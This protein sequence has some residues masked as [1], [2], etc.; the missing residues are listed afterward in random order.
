MYTQDET[1]TECPSCDEIR[2]PNVDPECEEYEWIEVDV[3]INT[4]APIQKE[5]NVQQPVPIVPEPI[6]KDKE[7]SSAFIADKKMAKDSFERK[8]KGE[9]SLGLILGIV[10]GTI[11]VAG[12]A[13]ATVVIVGFVLFK[14]RFQ[15]RSYNVMEHITDEYAVCIV[16]KK[17]FT[18]RF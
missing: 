11:G 7:N 6:P 15:M 4:S 14:R 10:F 17:I 2:I 13:I 12:L 16:Q 9:V 8:K 1:L 5:E 18:N 3:K